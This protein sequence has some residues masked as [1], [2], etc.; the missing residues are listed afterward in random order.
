MPFLKRC[1]DQLVQKS[2]IL[3]AFSSRK[4]NRNVRRSATQNFASYQSLEPRK[5][6]AVLTVTTAGDSPTGAD[7][8]DGLVSLREAITAA[9]TNAAFGDAAA[10]DASGDVIQF[11]S[12]LA[13]ETITLGGS[14]IEITDDLIIRGNSVVTLSGNDAS[15]IFSVDTAETVVF[16]RLTFTA[17]QSDEGGALLAQGGGTVRL[18]ETTFTSNAALVGPSGGGNGGAVANLGSRLLISNSVFENNSAQREGG[19]IYSAGGSLNFSGSSLSNNSAADGGGLSADGGQYSFN[20][21]TIE[22]NEVQFL[23]GGLSFQ[24]AD[25]TALF[26]A[27]T[28]D[29]NSTGSNGDMGGGGGIYL[30]D[31]RLFV[32]G[33]TVISGNNVPGFSPAFGSGGGILSE[34]GN[35]RI[36]GSEV[37]GNSVEGFG[38]GISIND[39]VLNVT[40]SEIIDNTAFGAGGIG[41]LDANL[42]LQST[43]LRRN[44]ATSGRGG[45]L[46][47]NGDSTSLIRGSSFQFNTAGTFG[48]AISNSGDNMTITS[49]FFGGNTALGQ[50]FNDITGGGGGIFNQGERLTINSSTIQ[51]NRAAGIVGQ[52]GGVYSGQGIVN[53]N[54]SSI[55]RNNAEQL[56]GGIAIVGGEATLFDSNIGSLD[57]DSNRAENGGGIF[58]GSPDLLDTTFADVSDPVEL[59]VFGGVIG[60]NV[61]NTLG[62]GV[63]S[64]LA[65]VTFRAASG[66]NETMVVGNRALRQDGGGLYAFGGRFNLVD[67]V[68]EENTS[69]DGA[70]I[71]ATEAAE[72]RLVRTDIR[73]NE[74]RRVG[75]GLYTERDSVVAQFDATIESNIAPSFPDV[76]Q[77]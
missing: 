20:S 8:N 64:R 74:A 2:Q 28:I 48:G 11:S 49:S 7:L 24:G 31:G 34:G 70:G 18:F 57:G 23:G 62:G 13:G 30:E 42:I 38:G 6:L 76:F 16:S 52:G 46:L 35:V 10:G 40:G 37:S 53:I 65:E 60:S 1:L 21:S 56:G 51:N 9:N 72:L 15:R 71:F 17:G 66:E 33:G 25:T 55:L 3:D 61:A 75:G 43:L 54:F 47:V 27:S 63:Y 4:A 36:G 59:T 26:I 22:G 12:A 50:E 58:V 19:G 14:E 73:L 41:A 45:G 29:Q 44:A 77:G 69:R 5:L 67:A 39:A 32:F 68:F